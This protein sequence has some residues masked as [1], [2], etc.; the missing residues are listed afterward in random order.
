MTPHHIP[1]VDVEPIEDTNPFITK[2]AILKT[3]GASYSHSVFSASINNKQV[4]NRDYPYEG[5]TAIINN[6]NWKF[7]DGIA[8]GLLQDGAPLPLTPTTV[9]I[10]PWQ[11]IFRYAHKT[12]V[13]E[14][15]YMLDSPSTADGVVCYLTLANKTDPKTTATMLE[16]SGIQIIAE[17]LFDIR[18]MYAQSEPDA[19][20]IIHEDGVLFVKREGHVI[21]L[22]IDDKSTNPPT[23][24]AD[25]RV[26]DWWYKLGSGYRTCG[27]E[28]CAN[29]SGEGEQVLSAGDIIFNG[30]ND[31]ITIVIACSN[32]AQTVR[33]LLDSA[34]HHD[35]VEEK[36]RQYAQEVEQKLMTASASSPDAL[37]TS[38][39]TDV[40]FRTLG[41]L[42]FGMRV[43]DSILH[44]AGDFWFKNVWF[45]D[46]FEG[47]LS[48]FNTLFALGHQG[49]IKNAVEKALE[50]Q[51][52][53]GR[54]P[55]NIP[56]RASDEIS[57]NSADATLLTFIAGGQYIKRM[58]E[59]AHDKQNNDDDTNKDKGCL[60]YTSPSP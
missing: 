26:Y 59:K 8:I 40:L 25:R 4:P 32:S 6:E 49:Y 33:K 12:G 2:H 57:Y 9:T 43:Q 10:R 45:R 39:T 38:Q 46:E 22:R 36:N 54:V 53:F 11:H 29:P 55:N 23:L 44:E 31:Q 51:D 37:A 35:A 60:L 21:G 28:K 48:N 24:H 58:Q 42:S 18:H 3:T 20:E 14:A 16:E 7:L 41:M 27:D 15:S 19:C 17:P 13:L 50:Y 5:L 56:T 47:L 30:E 34:P 52:I 1:S